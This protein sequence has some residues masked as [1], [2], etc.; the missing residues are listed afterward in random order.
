MTDLSHTPFDF[1]AVLGSNQYTLDQ[2]NWHPHHQALYANALNDAHASDYAGVVV[3]AESFQNCPSSYTTSRLLFQKSHHTYD[4]FFRSELLHLSATASLCA[5][6]AFVCL[7]AVFTQQETHI[8]IMRKD[9]GVEKLVFT[10]IDNNKDLHLEAQ[11]WHY[12]YQPLPEQRKTLREQ[13][14]EFNLYLS[15]LQNDAFAHPDRWLTDRSKLVCQGTAGQLTSFAALLLNFAHPL[16][17]KPEW[18]LESSLGLGGVSTGS[19]ELELYLPASIG[20]LLEDH[21]Y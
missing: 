15:M 21:T 19:V 5:S 10:C 12:H 18:A 16:N 17:P 8:E 1:H 14:T 3:T 11:S 6:I 4:S 2:I 13:G 7:Q 9:T 20:Y